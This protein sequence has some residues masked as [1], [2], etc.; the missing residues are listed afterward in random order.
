MEIKWC[1]SFD[2]DTHATYGNDKNSVVLVISNDPSEEKKK[3]QGMKN[4]DKID[5]KFAEY[6]VKIK[7][8]C[9]QQIM[10]VINQI[11]NIRYSCIQVALTLCSFTLCDSHFVRGLDFLKKN[12]HC[13]IFSHFLT[14]CGFFMSY[15]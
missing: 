1:D 4:V 7:E 11:S 13:A 3:V 12:S 8:K 2:S 15:F 14:L 9:D 5:W 6:D 10:D